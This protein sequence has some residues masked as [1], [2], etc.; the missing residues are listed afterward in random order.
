MVKPWTKERIREAQALLYS[1]LSLTQA[2]KQLGITRPALTNALRRH[3]Q[4]PKRVWV[5]SQ[6]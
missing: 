3:G 1:G 4:A 5:C 2:A 6:D